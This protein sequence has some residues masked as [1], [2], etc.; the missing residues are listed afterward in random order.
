MV[1]SPN[2]GIRLDGPQF[3][4]PHGPR[5]RAVFVQP[6]VSSR[7]MIAIDVLLQRANAVNEVLSVSSITVPDHE[8]RYCVPGERF[9]DLLPRPGR[10]R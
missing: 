6:Q 8:P 2:H 5:D 10:C 7:S 1:E 4:G 3:L 9:S